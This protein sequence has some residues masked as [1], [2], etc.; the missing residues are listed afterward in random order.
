MTTKANDKHQ[1]HAALARPQSGEF[2]RNEL[3]ILG[4][5]CNIINACAEKWISLLHEYH[6]A[7]VD[8]DHKAGEDAPGASI[9][10]TDKISYRRI[11]TQ[12]NFNSFTNR[13]LFNNQDIVLVNSNHFKADKQVVIVHPDKT[14]EH[15]LEKLTD[16]V[17]ILLSEGQSVPLYLSAHL[18]IDM[19]VMEL[20]DDSGIAAFIKDLLVK[21]ISPLNGLVLAGG[22][23][24]RMGTDKAEISYHGIPQRDYMQ[25]LLSPLCKD[26]FISVAEGEGQNVIADRFIGLGPFGGILSAMQYNPNT[27][28]LTIA[29]DLPYLSSATLAY[30]IEHRNPSKIATSF[31][32]SD[33][34]FPEPLITIWEPR[35]YPVMLNFLAQ[36]YSCPRKV[37][38]NSEIELLQAPDVSEFRNINNPDEREEA[39]RYFGMKA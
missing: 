27:A 25:Q 36:G 3:G 33:G 23:S 9:R 10:F 24:L 22:K 29:C 37:L 26:V 13:V 34:R 2:A 6:I 11:D 38:I 14:L 19:P 32:D 16:V 4:A 20:S 28:W 18:G 39:L 31:L 30:L 15:K 12:Q 17:L 8:A 1:K 7:Y 35:A 5:P 21:S